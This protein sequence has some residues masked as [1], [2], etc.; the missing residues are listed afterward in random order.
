[1]FLSSPRF[2]LIKSCNFTILSRFVRVPIDR[3]AVREDPKARFDFN[4]RFDVRIN[5]T[6]SRFRHAEDTAA[7]YRENRE[8]RGG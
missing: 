3:E 2:F 7:N 1:M 8:D 5:D 4:G 6:I